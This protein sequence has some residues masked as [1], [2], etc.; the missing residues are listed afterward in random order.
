MAS[1]NHIET[2]RASSSRLAGS[3][4]LVCGLLWCP[5][6]ARHAP[7]AHGPFI[8]AVESQVVDRNGVE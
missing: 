2:I 4:L 7:Y 5:E 3:S 1:M 6:V 8:D